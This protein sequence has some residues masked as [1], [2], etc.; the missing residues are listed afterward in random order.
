MTKTTTKKIVG[1]LFISHIYNLAAHILGVASL[2]IIL[3]L[4]FSWDT[5]DLCTIACVHKGYIRSDAD[6]KYYC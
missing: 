5:P 4:F 2:E 1:G 6:R 3:I